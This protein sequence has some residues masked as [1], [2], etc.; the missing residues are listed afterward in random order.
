M[1]VTYVTFA[2]DLCFTITTHFHTPH[3]IFIFPELFFYYY[4]GEIALW[5]ALAPKYLPERKPYRITATMK[6]HSFLKS[7][8]LKIIS[9]QPT[10]C[11]NYLHEWVDHCY[12]WRRL[13]WTNIVKVEHSLNGT[14]LQ[15]PNY[16]LC[17]AGEQV[18][19]RLT[20]IIAHCRRSSTAA[21]SLGFTRLSRTCLTAATIT[22][23]LSTDNISPA[24]AQLFQCITAE[25]M[26]DSSEKLLI[27]QL[28]W[29]LLYR[30]V[31]S[32]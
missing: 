11:H 17:A 9:L 29:T 15:A 19:W 27:Q 32:L 30:Y 23:I 4:L 22:T 5:K 20:D 26:T 21:A 24:S 2:K 8:N 18:Y 10:N 13:S 6:R 12:D 25:S 7:H 16:G 28:A 1:L 14:R 3:T 31:W